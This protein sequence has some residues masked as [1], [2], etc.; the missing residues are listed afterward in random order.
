MGCLT[1]LELWFPLR[2][3]AA[4]H[5]ALGGAAMLTSARRRDRTRMGGGRD[6][7]RH[8]KDLDGQIRRAQHFSPLRGHLVPKQG[9]TFTEKRCFSSYNS[10]VHH[11]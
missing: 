4:I 10:L 6:N 7:E 1:D 5:R 11:A 9:P 8:S 2:V 3:V